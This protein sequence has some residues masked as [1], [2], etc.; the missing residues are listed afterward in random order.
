MATTTTTSTIVKENSEI[1]RAEAR[2]EIWFSH[3][4]IRKWLL[5]FHATADSLNAKAFSRKFFTEDIEVQYGN[6]PVVK[7]REANEK[8]FEQAFGNLGLMK[9]DLVYFDVVI[10]A[11]NDSGQRD[12]VQQQEKDKEVE[13]VRIYQAVKIRYVVKGD[14]EQDQDAS[15]VVPAFLAGFVVRH[16]SRPGV[17]GGE[18]VNGELKFRRMEIYLDVSRVFARMTEKGLL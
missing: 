3:T 10:P 14:S 17:E 8:N 15:F 11:A 12:G 5:D 7:G 18:S 16:A 1:S 2:K 6:N 13:E 9:H 4:N